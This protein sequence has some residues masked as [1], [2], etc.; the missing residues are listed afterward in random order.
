MTTYSEEA[1]PNPKDC[2]DPHHDHRVSSVSALPPVICGACRYKCQSIEGMTEHMLEHAE[3]LVNEPPSSQQA[4]SLTKLLEDHT[5][6]LIALMESVIETYIYIDPALSRGQ[7]VLSLR[8]AQ[9]EK[10][11]KMVG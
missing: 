10:L 4:G 1:C 6:E 8:A 3:D 5:K 2:S 7:L 9:L 11:R